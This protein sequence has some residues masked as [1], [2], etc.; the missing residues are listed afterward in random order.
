MNKQLCTLLTL[1][2]AL[3]LSAASSSASAS[4]SASADDRSDERAAD[5]KRA[6]AA[7]SAQQRPDLFAILDRHH[8]HNR[9]C[10]SLWEESEEAGDSCPK[11]VEP[12]TCMF[13][14]LD[15]T[16]L[17]DN[18]DYLPRFSKTDIALKIKPADLCEEFRV[19]L[20]N[21]A[22]PNQ[23][24]AAG[25]PI[26]SATSQIYIPELRE[27]LI[28]YGANVNLPDKESYTPLFYMLV[29]SA[30][31]EFGSNT[32]YQFESAAM[33]LVKAGFHVF[34]PGA[35]YHNDITGYHY[36]PAYLLR[37]PAL[38]PLMNTGVNANH[39]NN[40]GLTV[41]QLLMSHDSMT[42]NT[43]NDIEFL[44]N[45]GADTP[46][47]DTHDK[48]LMKALSRVYEN[49]FSENGADYADFD[50][51]R[52]L[53]S[54]GIGSTGVSV[55]EDAK[56]LTKM[57][58][59]ATPID[60]D[61]NCGGSYGL[62]NQDAIQEGISKAV[63]EG[64]KLYRQ[65]LAIQHKIL[66]R[67]VTQLGLNNKLTPASSEGAPSVVGIINEYAGVFLPLE[68]EGSHEDNSWQD[69]L[70][71]DHVREM[72]AQMEIQ[73]AA[74]SAASSSASATSQAASAA[75]VAAMQVDEDPNDDVR[76]LPKRTKRKAPESSAQSSV[77]SSS[78]SASAPAMDVDEG[79]IKSSASASASAASSS[80]SSVS[81][82]KEAGNEG[83]ASK[84]LRTK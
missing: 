40:D 84:K 14:Q 13:Y 50:F 52:M 9:Y 62:C 18:S 3:Q 12:N 80:A 35:R 54:Y 76:G 24:N 4:A 29:M 71:D 60:N 82:T 41:F 39:T 37:L 1:L 21:G 57:L 51:I 81:A 27:L 69:F 83:P 11:R 79:D 43:V 48:I 38:R 66:D 26:L 72:E 73:T 49:S 2:S 8:I 45:L 42:L 75:G 5:Q 59:D 33:K 30:K 64:L 78:A 25:T 10:Q 55:E 70:K 20:E 63:S 19:A 65:R 34:H 6:Y 68:K 31:E 46:S 28:K 32:D 67:A 47:D 44:I 74:S 16:C 22:D 61:C 7:A 53:T 58:F 15:N 77:D 56:R 17:D 36:E 23:R